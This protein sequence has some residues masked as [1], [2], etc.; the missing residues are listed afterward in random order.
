VQAPAECSIVEEL[1]R[2]AFGDDRHLGDVA[3]VSRDKF[4][5]LNEIEP[6]D[7]EIVT[8]GRATH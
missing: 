7:L 4:A 5:A 3:P 2:Q 8:T 6:H 1:R